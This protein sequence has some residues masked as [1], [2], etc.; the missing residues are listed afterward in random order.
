MSDAPQS[1]TTAESPVL[2]PPERTAIFPE[3][4]A[5][6]LLQAAC[7]VKPEGITG[8]FTATARDLEGV[9]AGLEKYLAAKGRKPRDNWPAYFRQV[10][11][12]RQD[13]DRFLFLSYFVSD[14]EAGSEGSPKEG[15]A[16]DDSPKWKREPYWMNDG[17]DAY[18]RVIFDLQ[19]REFVW[20]E[21]NSDP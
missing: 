9:E 12:L 18:F 7:F 17:G 20:Y 4:K 1:P 14:P 16:A 5:S 2:V 13:G 8:Y 15:A 11:G 6:A 10:A 19:K 3:A 21:R